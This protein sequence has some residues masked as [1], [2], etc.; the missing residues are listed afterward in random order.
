LEARRIKER[1][2]QAILCKL[3]DINEEI[4][5]FPLNV[6]YLSHIECLSYFIQIHII[7]CVE[8]VNLVE[9]LLSF[10]YVCKTEFM[11]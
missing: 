8:L 10:V 5:A 1:L 4:H 2:H 6:L 9:G 7:I 11:E 3:L